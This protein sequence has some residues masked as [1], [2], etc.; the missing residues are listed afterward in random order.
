MG[1]VN[2]QYDSTLDFVTEADLKNVVDPSDKQRIRAYQLYDDMYHTRP[3]TFSV[4][5]RGDSDIEIYL[6]SLK[7][8]VNAVS[9]FLAVGMDFVIDPDN[10]QTNEQE[11]KDALYQYLQ[12][13]FVREKFYQKIL[14]QKRTMLTKGDAVW[15]IVADDT[16]E[17]D[18]QLSIYTVDPSHYFPEEDEDGRV[19]AVMLVD[20]IPDPDDKTKTVARVQTYRREYETNE[21]GV[22]VFTGQILSKLEHYE[23]GGW[24]YR[25]LDSDSIKLLRVIRPEEPLP[26]SIKSIPV[27]HIPNTPPNGSS[28]GLSL[29]AG[30][31]YIMNALNQS[32]TYEDLT[33]ILNGL[34]I[35][36]STAGPPQDPESGEPT[37]YDLSPGSVAEIGEGQDL[38]RVSGVTTVEPFQSHLSFL[39]SAAQ[40]AIG[41]PDIAVGQVDV[42]VVE[43]GVALAL[44]M[45]PMLADNAD[46][47]LEILGVMDQMLYDLV[48]Y[49]LPVYSPIDPSGIIVRFK[50]D[51]PM[52]VNRDSVITEIT[53]LYTSGL[54]TFDMAA[55]RL[56]KLGYKFPEN[57]LL[58]I[59]TEQQ[60]AA[61]IFPGDETQGA[62]E[63]VT[64]DEGV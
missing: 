8:Y 4:T 33:L 25:N 49:W 15:H 29:G 41:I 17:L 35:Y 11:R 20:E 36:V 7:K 10:F 60:A 6:P 64:E 45:G 31:E 63:P 26:E 48:N 44:K 50:V 18:R 30:I 22:K 32:A 51:D 43:S 9:R 37:T 1:Y 3:E 14:Q 56:S 61:G 59:I 58:Q 21:N 54:I 2:R 46:R 34:G 47:E 27:Y 16:K 28:W 24:D 52:P 40:Q 38:R 12:N 23:L 42:S 5:L 13:L 39:D 57:A 19:I 55:E 62:E 53:T